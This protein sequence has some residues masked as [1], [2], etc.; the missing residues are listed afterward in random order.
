MR[1]HPLRA[2][3]HVSGWIAGKLVFQ[4]EPTETSQQSGKRFLVYISDI[5]HAPG[6]LFFLPFF[7]GAGVVGLRNSPLMALSRHKGKVATY[8]QAGE[9]MILSTFNSLVL[10]HLQMWSIERAPIQG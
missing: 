4:K 10:K 2:L 7:L 1:R 6:K 9:K 3:R 5:F 8:W